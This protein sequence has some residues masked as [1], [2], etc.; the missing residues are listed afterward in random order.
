[1]LKIEKHLYLLV[2]KFLMLIKLEI[3]LCF[4]VFLNSNRPYVSNE[5][6]KQVREFMCV[7][8]CVCVIFVCE[9]MFVVQCFYLF[10]YTCV[11]CVFYA[12]VCLYLC[13]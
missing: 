2:Y 6:S 9:R 8:I 4:V 7:Y 13:R 1:M 11:V 5:A 10:V 12:S 3:F